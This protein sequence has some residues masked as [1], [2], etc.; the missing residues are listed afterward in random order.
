LYFKWCGGQSIDTSGLKD[1]LF[2]SHRKRVAVVQDG[3]G[4]KELDGEI[5]RVIAGCG[6]ENQHL[7]HFYLIYVLSNGF[8]VEIEPGGG[9][10]AA[11]LGSREVP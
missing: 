6:S 1:N 2:E 11:V 9:S 10:L 4:I 5:C 7:S 3:E 8:S